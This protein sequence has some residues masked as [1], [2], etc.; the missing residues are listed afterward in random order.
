MNINFFFVIISIALM[1]IFTLFKP[2]NIKTQNF[3]ET[4]LLEVSSF[5]LHELN[6]LGI[7]T[8]MKGN[9]AFRYEDRYLV[10][11]IDYTDNSKKYKANMIADKGVYKDDIVNLSGNIIYSREDGLIFK[12]QKA[13]YD[14]V[15]KIATSTTDY[16]AY[17]G[18][19]NMKGSFLKY[20]NE[21]KK[22]ESKNVNIIYQLKEEKL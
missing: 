1:M 19:S 11:N 22:I 4:P 8:V 15:N 7:I 9:N 12:T 13:D 14:K 20:D 2:L 18:K 5:T 16:I 21:N 10:E 6:T 3:E 17:M